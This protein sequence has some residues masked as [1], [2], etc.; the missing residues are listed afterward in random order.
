MLQVNR[1]V[2]GIADARIEARELLNTDH[3]STFPS[4][5]LAAFF[6][7]LTQALL[8]RFNSDQEKLLKVLNVLPLAL[9]TLS[10]GCATQEVPLND[11]L[12]KLTAQA[13]LPAVTANEYCNAQMDSDIL[14]GTGLLMYEHGSSETAQTC[15]VMAAPK[16]P[17]AFC[18]LSTIEMQSGD[19]S[20]NKD[21]VFNYTAYAAKQN[22]WCAEYGMYDMYRSGTLG[23]KKDTALATRWLLRSSQH[24]YPDAQKH[25]IKQ[26]EAQGNLAEAYAWSKFLTDT[27]DTAIGT[28]LITRMTPEQVA[29]ADKRY[30]ELVPQVASKAALAAEERAED[31]ARYSAQIY[32]DY[33]DTF[34]GLTSAER[35][36]YMSQSIGDAMDL[37]FIRNRDH[38]LIYIVINRAAQLKKAD[39]NIA[40]DQRIIALIEDKR[41]TVDE[42]IES[43]LL[44]VSKLYK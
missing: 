23:A 38:V 33:P 9:L 4:G 21:R 39:A 37:P 32:Q 19:L 27:E 41:L 18:Y 31:V 29:E 7:C 24:G 1:I 44:E 6:A 22:D 26:Y 14:F 3:P 40:N 25:L 17:R 20:K 5:N 34:K 13:L 36:A 2:H 16:H 35:Y 8:V 43:G 30:N 10:G 11:T 42:T 28:T 15:L 12:P